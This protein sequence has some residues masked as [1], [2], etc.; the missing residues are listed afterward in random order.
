MVDHVGWK[1]A[2]TAALGKVGETLAVE[3]VALTANLTYT[4][5]AGVPANTI[6]RVVFTQNGTGGHTVTYG[7][8]PV[9]VETTAGAQTLVEFWPGGEVAYPG[10][11]DVDWSDV[12]NKPA[13]YTPSAHTQAASTITDFAEA[14]QDAVAAML[15]SGANVT[16]TY[17]DALGK[18]TVTASGGDAELM[19]DTIGA[20]IVGT[21]GVSVAVNDAA[22]TITLSISGVTAAQVSGLATVATTGAY[23]DL[24]DKPTIPDSPDDISAAPASGQA[25][26]NALTAG[27]TVTIP[28]KHSMHTLTM[29]GNT[30]LAFSNPPSGHSFTL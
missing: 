21:S 24:S 18:V 16:L 6:H 22:D 30:T 10:S 13:T 25:A 5:P 9:T 15:V 26:V 28:A 3:Q 17:D 23:A 14:V 20:A 1:P 8:Q 29:T 4:L 11:S 19:R 7:G 12:T 27:A 2:L